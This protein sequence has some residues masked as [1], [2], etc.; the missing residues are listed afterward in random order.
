MLNKTLFL[1]IIKISYVV[2][3]KDPDDP[4]AKEYERDNANMILVKEDG[5]WK[6]LNATI[7]D[8]CNGVYNVG[9][10]S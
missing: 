10:E 7:V 8:M 1:F 9:K 5:A 2:I 6:I 4:N 3:G